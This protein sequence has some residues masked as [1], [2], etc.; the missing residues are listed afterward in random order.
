[1]RTHRE[2]APG[3]RVRIVEGLMAD[4]IVTVID[5]RGP[6]ARVLLPMFGTERPVDV[7]AMLLEAA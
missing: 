6:I 5:V 3:Q 1:M 7:A 2:Y 4:R